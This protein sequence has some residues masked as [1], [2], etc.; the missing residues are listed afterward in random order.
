M[1]ARVKCSIYPQILEELS[2]K[3][4]NLHSFVQCKEEL[5]PL[6]INDKAPRF[7]LLYLDVQ[8][9]LQKQQTLR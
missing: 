3:K 8:I 6:G 1:D 7:S 2:C 5:K 9:E 4:R